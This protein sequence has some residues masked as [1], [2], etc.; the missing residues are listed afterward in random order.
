[1]PPKKEATQVQDWVNSAFKGLVICIFSMFTFFVNQL[2]GSINSLTTQLKSMESH[3]VESD[4]RIAAIEVS[5]EINMASYQ[6]LVSD[7]SEMKQSMIQNTMRLQTISDF[8]S[9]HFK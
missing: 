8:V 7:V 6:K 5:R 1:M 9:K 2:N 4:K 3:Q